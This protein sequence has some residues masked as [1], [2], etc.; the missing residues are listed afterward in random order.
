MWEEDKYHRNYNNSNSKPKDD[1]YVRYTFTVPSSPGRSGLMILIS[2]ICVVALSGILGHFFGILGYIGGA[3]GGLFLGGILG[4]IIGK[5]FI[6]ALVILV[7]LG[8]CL[9]LAKPY[10][11][12]L[13]SSVIPNK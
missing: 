3:V 6:K 10:I 11:M 13:L 2:I 5:K 9:Y 1:G 8:V 7:I 4:S 12:P